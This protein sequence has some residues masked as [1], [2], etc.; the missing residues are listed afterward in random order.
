MGPEA[1]PLPPPSPPPISPPAAH[2]LG[3]GVGV[4]AHPSQ[5]LAELVDVHPPVP[6]RVQL[7]EEAGPALVAIGVAGAL[8]GRQL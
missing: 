7:L 5:A 3:V 8:L 4:H 2:L 6:V 1:S